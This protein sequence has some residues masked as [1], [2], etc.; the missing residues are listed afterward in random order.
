MIL[1]EELQKVGKLLK[2]HGINGEIVALLTDDVD[3]AEVSCVV[4]CID[5]INVPFF[6]SSVR[7]KSSETDLITVDGIRDE[8]AAAALCG[9]DLYVKRSEMPSNDECDGFY[10][11]DLVGFDVY[12]D[13]ELIGKITGIND[14]TANYLFI[15]ERPDGSTCLVPVADEFIDILDPETRRIELRL[16]EGLLDL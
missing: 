5:G 13:C 3:L 9:H 6:I 7:R 14:S 16:P 8:T 10:A 15:I 2:P 12:S 1:Q 11:D 4:I